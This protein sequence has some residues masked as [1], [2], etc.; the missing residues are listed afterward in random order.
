MVAANTR[1]CG[2]VCEALYLSKEERLQDKLLLL[3]ILVVCDKGFRR[4]GQ[5]THQY[6]VGSAYSTH[7]RAFGEK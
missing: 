3:Q 6:E 1:Y 2:S 5:N 4:W 7:R